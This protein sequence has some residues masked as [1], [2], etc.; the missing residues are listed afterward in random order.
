MSDLLLGTGDGPLLRL[1]QAYPLLTFFAVLFTGLM[2][3]GL[4]YPQHITGT[5]GDASDFGDW[6]DGSGGD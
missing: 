4:M 3:Y 1:V 5:G 2:I 6:G